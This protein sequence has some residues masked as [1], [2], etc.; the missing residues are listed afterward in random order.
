MTDHHQNNT[1]KFLFLQN[2]SPVIQELGG[3]GGGGGG[4]EKLVNSTA[5]SS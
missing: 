4:A 1:Q 2:T 3:G 5:W